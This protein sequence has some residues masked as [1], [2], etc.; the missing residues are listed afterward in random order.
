MRACFEQSPA[1]PRW[2]QAS[3]D[4]RLC[5]ALHAIHAEA[6]H[7]W[8]VPE[9]ASL[10]GL[11][12]PAFGPELR[13]ITRPSANAVSADTTDSLRASGDEASWPDRLSPFMLGEAR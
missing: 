4:P 6:G 9:L 11:S 12:R 5:P 3:S 8:I 2:Y 7:P 10:S 13:T 1:A